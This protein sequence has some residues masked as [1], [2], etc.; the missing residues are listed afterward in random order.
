MKKEEILDITRAIFKEV[1]MEDSLEIQLETTAADIEGWDSLTHI[2]LVS[3]IENK[4]SIQFSFREVMNF[5]S[6]SDM[7]DVIQNRM[8]K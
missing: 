6:V 3:A 5:N 2:E 1:F 7:I 4:F 8:K